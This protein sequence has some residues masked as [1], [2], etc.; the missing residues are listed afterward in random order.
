[1]P[2]P[3]LKPILQRFMQEE[4][5][6]TDLANR[7]AHFHE[8][9]SGS[10][11]VITSQDH[12]LI[13]EICFLSFMLEWE[14]FIEDTFSRFLCGGDRFTRPHPQLTG[15][16]FNSI[17][18][19]KQ[20]L[21]GKRGYVRW[22]DPNETTRLA[23]QYFLNGEPFSTPYRIASQELDEVR[24]IRNR[25]GHSSTS[26]DSIFMT[27]IRAKYGYTPRGMTPG[28]FLLDKLPNSQVEN[29]YNYYTQKLLRVAQLILG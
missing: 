8:A 23:T 22:I 6:V 24:I 10:I 29:Q 2:K 1:M 9:R 11:K 7:S 27:M 5:R 18:N 26:A 17:E 25:I 3:S 20:Q 12:N 14:I 16:R 13:V 15:A 19:A 4:K 28:R 21:L